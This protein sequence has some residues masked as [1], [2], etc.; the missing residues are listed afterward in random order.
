MVSKDDLILFLRNSVFLTQF[1]QNLLP[2]WPG[3]KDWI[4]AALLRA[5]KTGK[6]STAMRGHKGIKV[7]PYKVLSMVLVTVEHSQW[8]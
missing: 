8:S 3:S 4:N 1:I 7:M 6:S 2:E 5:A